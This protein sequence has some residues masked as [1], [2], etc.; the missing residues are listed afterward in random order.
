M[1][2]LGGRKEK[3]LLPLL[4]AAA[5]LFQMLLPFAAVYQAPGQTGATGSALSFNGKIIICTPEG[6]KLVSLEDLRNGAEKPA[7]DDEYQCPLCYL[8]AHQGIRQRVA[9]L[10]AAP[11]PVTA[12]VFLFPASD[13]IHSYKAY[14]RKPLT[15]APPS[16][17]FA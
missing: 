12:Q 11:L 1:K 4:T 3:R 14:G 5:L 13:A 8:A 17:S 2:G 16:P 9:D 7:T 6:F 10:A 15:R